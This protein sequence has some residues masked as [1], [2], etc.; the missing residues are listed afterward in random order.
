[1]RIS[2]ILR[3]TD[4]GIVSQHVVKLI[5]S[6][7]LIISLFLIIVNCLMYLGPFMWVWCCWPG[8]KFH[9]CYEASLSDVFVETL[10]ITSLLSNRIIRRHCYYPGEFG[11]IVVR[12]LLVPPVLLNRGNCSQFWWTDVPPSIFEVVIFASFIESLFFAIACC[13]R[14]W[15]LHATAL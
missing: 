7:L 12:P 11:V 1:M 10:V 3:V 15:L 14:S 4:R 8:C 9:P 13:D 5:I 2:S 6:A